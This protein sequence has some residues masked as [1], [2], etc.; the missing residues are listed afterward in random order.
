MKIGLIA[1]PY[2]IIC[3]SHSTVSA[4]HLMLMT[5]QNRFYYSLFKD[6]GSNI[7]KVKVT[8]KVT[9]LVS[10]GTEI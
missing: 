1:N 7:Q 9:Q 4:L 3:V 5:T 8:C 2:L 10:G 6:E